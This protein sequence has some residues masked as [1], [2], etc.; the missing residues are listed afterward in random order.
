[1]YSVF[2]FH[3]LHVIVSKL[4]NHLNNFNDCPKHNWTFVIQAIY[5]GMNK[6][7]SAYNTYLIGHKV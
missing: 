5:G 6:Y 4:Y 2:K 3:F 1:M 7:N